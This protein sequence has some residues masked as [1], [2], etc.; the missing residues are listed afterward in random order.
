MYKVIH[1]FGNTLA[2]WGNL[3]KNWGLDLK[4]WAWAKIWGIETSFTFKATDKEV[5]EDLYKLYTDESPVDAAWPIFMEMKSD[6][7]LGTEMGRMIADGYS[8]LLQ[9]MMDE[10][11]D[12]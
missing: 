3:L 1:G 9:E 5:A 6:S 7:I 11:N 12:H 10:E 8:R 4:S 2:F